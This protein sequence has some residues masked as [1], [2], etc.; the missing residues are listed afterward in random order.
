[1]KLW[2][3]R[4]LRLNLT[5]LGLEFV[6]IM[7]ILGLFAVNSGNNLL[8][9]LFALMLGLFFVSGWVS[10]RSIKGLAF[11]KVEE[12]SVFARVRG[13]LRLYLHEAHPGRTRGVEIRMTMGRGQ[14]EP[15]F[16]AR[17][18]PGTREVKIV[19]HIRP[20]LRGW[21]PLT[22]LE[23]R[24]CFPFGFLEKSLRFPL[25]ESILVL[26]HPRS[27]RLKLGAL[28]DQAK[29][30]HRPGVASP[31]G[32][33]PFR[34]GDPL[35]RVH[36]KRTAQR[37]EPWVRSFEDEQPMGIRLKLDLADWSP[38]PAFEKELERLSGLILQARIH[39][40]SVVLDL[41]SRAGR[42]LFDGVRAC[43]RALAVAQ[44]EEQRDNAPSPTGTP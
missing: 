25:E 43:W 8:Y 41:R 6:G 36:W 13:G 26:P 28:G 40:R 19:L 12:G 29:R 31:E 30:T 11:A 24:T 38:G 34:A 16:L 32:V 5:R 14:V 35:R 4:R 23:L 1:M 2:N 18:E 22:E 9:L 27:A 17:V 10:V 20:D 39:R 42:Q 33:R 37:G 3:D 44:P 15:G 7:V 21:C